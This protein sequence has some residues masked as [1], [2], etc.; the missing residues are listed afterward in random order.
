MMQVAE[1]IKD[2]GPVPV[3]NRGVKAAEPQHILPNISQEEWEEIVNSM[4]EEEWALYISSLESEKQARRT[5]NLRTTQWPDLAG[6]EMTKQPASVAPVLEEE[7][8]MT[9]GFLEIEEDESLHSVDG[10]V[11]I[12]DNEDGQSWALLSGRDD[13][14]SVM[15]WNGPIQDKTTTG[16]KSRSKHVFTKAL[17]HTPDHDN[18]DAKDDTLFELRESAKTMRGG[19]PPFRTGM[20][21]RHRRQKK[22]DETITPTRQTVG[23]AM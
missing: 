11:A 3:A 4:T 7:S 20:T 19:K 23:L 14:D 9:E 1:S 12:E 10:F 5:F 18:E 8:V 15:S 22:S 21:R 2:H 16:K 17:P 13:V 6:K